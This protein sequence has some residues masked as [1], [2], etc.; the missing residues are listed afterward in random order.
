MGK[1]NSHLNIPV[2]SGPA[3]GLKR[4]SRE[5]QIQAIEAK[6]K[7]MQRGVSPEFELKPPVVKPSTSG[8]TTTFKHNR[9]HSF[10]ESKRRK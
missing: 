8:S 7:F 10:H 5:S 9:K 3:K 6:L 4:P 1:D 2:L